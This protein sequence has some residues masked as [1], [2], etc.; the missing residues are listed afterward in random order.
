MSLKKKSLIISIIVLMLF[1]LI[2]FNLKVSA[3]DNS[4]YLD[5]TTR[6]DNENTD[7]EIPVDTPT[8]PAPTTQD[9]NGNNNNGN[10]N[11]DG[12]NTNEPGQLANTGLEDLPWAI[13]AVCAVSTVFAY[14]KIKEYKDA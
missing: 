3:N 2:T 14:K 11:V 5:L 6:P 7:D 8:T 9:G 10:S 4:G 12:N 1:A 13:I